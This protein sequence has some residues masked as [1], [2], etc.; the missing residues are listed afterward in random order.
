[1]RDARDSGR[2]SVGGIVVEMVARARRDPAI[3]GSGDTVG[4]RPCH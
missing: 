4:V 2:F 1:M 3:F